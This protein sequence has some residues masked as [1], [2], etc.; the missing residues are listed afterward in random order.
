MYKIQ[1]FLENRRQNFI[2]LYRLSMSAKMAA[3]GF[4]PILNFYVVL[5]HD[6]LML[7][8]W[9]AMSASRKNTLRLLFYGC[10]AMFLAQILLSTTVA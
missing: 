6:A 2:S 4:E 1:Y 5:V 3:N 7:V 8:E 10:F 9:C